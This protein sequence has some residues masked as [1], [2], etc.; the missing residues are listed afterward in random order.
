MFA[1]SV[2][3]REATSSQV[4]KETYMIGSALPEE[5][6]GEATPDECA[7]AGVAGEDVVANME[8]SSS[9]TILV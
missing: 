8:D 6:E 5:D 9:A 3:V 2:F 7:A 1:K 4:G